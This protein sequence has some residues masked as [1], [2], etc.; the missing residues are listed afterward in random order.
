MSRL[1]L[2][3]PPSAYL[4]DTTDLH[5]V[6]PIAMTQPYMATWHDPVSNVLHPVEVIV[7][8]SSV[9]LVLVRRP[10]RE[11]CLY[12]MGPTFHIGVR[13]PWT[14]DGRDWTFYAATA[15]PPELDI[16]MTHV[17]N[18]HMYFL[19]NRDGHRWVTHD[20]LHKDVAAGL[21]HDKSIEERKSSGRKTSIKMQELMYRRPRDVISLGLD[22]LA[23]M[24]TVTRMFMGG[25]PLWS[26]SRDFLKKPQWPTALAKNLGWRFR[27][28]SVLGPPISG[29]LPDSLLRFTPEEF[30]TEDDKEESK[31]RVL[32]SLGISEP[33][34]TK[35]GLD[36][37]ITVLLPPH[38]SPTSYGVQSPE[39]MRLQDIVQ[40]TERDTAERA[41]RVAKQTQEADHI[42]MTGAIVI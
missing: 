6:G 42:T 11:Q 17:A 10:S 32:K 29:D 4:I 27:V 35:L 34:K 3:D 2:P 1:Y 15:S 41:L 16:L 30:W 22:P 39:R 9:P 21:L 12:F 19:S 40:K 13:P 33:V 31:K 38:L 18:D 7:W 25:R 37:S 14:D 26:T 8:M 23:K 20:R 24:I 28:I 5:V 36:P